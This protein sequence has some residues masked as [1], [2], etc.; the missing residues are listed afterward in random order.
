LC[1]LG[2]AHY[3]WLTPQPEIWFLWVRTGQYCVGGNGTCKVMPP[4][5]QSTV[6]PT[7]SA[8]AMRTRGLHW[9]ASVRLSTHLTE[10]GTSTPHWAWTSTTASNQA[11]GIWN[12]PANFL[13][14]IPV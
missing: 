7:N 1:L 10:A 13:L 3:H 9:A 8:V 11:W 4:G 14:G 6:P 2:R 12:P 5:Q